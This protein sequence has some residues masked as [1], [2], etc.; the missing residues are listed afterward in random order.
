[1]VG[2]MHGKCQLRPTGRKTLIPYVC[3]RLEFG[4]FKK[5]SR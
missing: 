3:L 2:Q 5:G 1:M 4:Q